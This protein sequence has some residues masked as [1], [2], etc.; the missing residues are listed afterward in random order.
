MPHSSS[1]LAAL[2]AQVSKF[3]FL[4][5]LAQPP[6][7][8]LAACGFLLALT[9]LATHAQ[10]CICPPPGMV[11]W[12]PGD[13]NPNDIVGGNPA[14]L[15][16]GATFAVGRVAQSFSL[17]G[18][19]DGISISK[20]PALNLGASDFTIDAWVKFTQIVGGSGPIF[21]NYA[22]VPYYHLVVDQNGR[23]QVSFRPGVAIVGGSNPGVTAT[24]TT[25]LNDGKW[26]HVAGVRSR[27]TALI[28]VDGQLEGSA[29]NP[30][31]LTVNWGGVDTSGCQFAR[32]GSVHTTSGHCTSL[33][34]NPAEARFQGL[35]DEVEVFNRALCAT[36]IQAIFNA[37]KA[38]K[39]KH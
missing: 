34:P 29:T 11:A 32:I 9:P 14:T 22:G 39:C 26:H 31:V 25:A 24:G 12:W 5:L 8:V 21:V 20:S 7:G 27:A 1:V 30:V 23:A 28:Y 16:S 35:I 37:G 4:R 15:V 17:D 3:K 18:V 19:N 36:E 6:L 38:G 13:G 2:L 33:N 10:T